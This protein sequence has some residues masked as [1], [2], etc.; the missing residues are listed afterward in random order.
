MIA[1][2]G[3]PCTH[4]DCPIRSRNILVFLVVIG[5]LSVGAY[6]ALRKT[7]GG[8]H[9]SATP[10]RSGVVREQRSVILITV[11]TTRPD[12]LEPYGAEHV[13]TP[14]LSRLASRGIVFE[15]AWAVAPI[16]LVAHTSILSGRY[17]FDHGVRNNGTQYVSPSVTTLA[18]KLQAEGYKTA[19]FVSA[20]VLDKRYGLDQGFDVYDDDLS[21][22][23]NLSPRMVADRPAE[24]TVEATTR[25]L[26]TLGTGEKF[27]TWVHFYD[28]HAGYSPPAPFRDVYRDRLYDGEI[29]YMDEQ[30]G[31]LLAHP[32][33][34]GAEDDEPLVMV[35]G[36][37]GESLGEHGERTHAILAYDSTLH[38][39]WI[40]Y[41]PGGPSG[42]RIGEPVGQVDLMPTVLGMLGME[43][44]KVGSEERSEMAGRD[45]T[46]IIEGRARQTAHPYYSETY[47]PFYT[48][49]WAKL[50]V[51]HRG[52]WK[53]I[54]APTPELYDRIRD[55]RELTDLHGTQ[56][57]V[58]HDLK[59]DLDEW[60]S[61]FDADQEASLSLDSEALAKLRSLG[62]LSVG[63]GRREEGRERPNPMDMIDQHVGLE[64]ARMFLADK[65]YSQAQRQLEGVLRRDPQNLAAL[66]DL[67]RAH[68]GQDQIGEALKLAERALELDPEYTQTYMMLARLEAQR[69]DFNRALELVDLAAERDPGNPDV[70]IQ[71]A[72]FLQRSG[73]LED[74]GEVLAQLLTDHPDHP[75]ANAFYAHFVEARTGQVEEAE[76]RLLQVV[77]WD[78]YLDQAWLFLGRAQERLGR[79][80]AAE[81]SYR[82]G[83]T[84]RP[85]DADLHGALG[86]LLARSGR[87]G[88]AVSQL[89]EAIRLTPRERTELHVSLGSVLAEMGRAEE[90]QRQYDKVLET[91]P[92]H[93]GARNNAAIALYRSGRAEE[94][95]AAL[96]QVVV[97]FPRHADALNNL[98]AIAVDQEEWREAVDYSRKTLDLAPELV[99]AW[100]NLAIGLE[101]IGELVEA[102]SAY[103]KTLA[104]DPEYWPGYFNLGLL[105]KKTEQ[106]AE[107]V[108]AFDQV[109][110]RIP[111]HAETHL[112][113]GELYAD[114]GGEADV[115]KAKAHWN[116]FLRH[117]PAHPRREEILRKLSRL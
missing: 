73:R 25:W 101:G 30:I 29:A 7:S 36:D 64:R 80:D 91:N 2:S 82:K 13:S 97:D 19:A 21:S 40:T 41:L 99:E 9:Q 83:L 8:E 20:A 5:L 59:R 70:R 15:R 12:R 117:A 94:A 10:S 79:T 86:H 39:P 72:G 32:R 6:L 11:D 61:Q 98:A 1:L 89:Q 90:A 78:P 35:I 116:A 26:D 102:R 95:K 54:D 48:Y 68:E 56:T 93:P 113:L 105:F 58:A 52:R 23:R 81:S 104:L 33:L 17:P 50:K 115:A 28:P 67:V 111:N 4:G 75:R 60:L 87:H 103:E 43:Q 71:K 92:R 106:P 69:N 14:T 22:R 77:D 63:S 96:E 44:E 16:T 47:L 18:E 27:F 45:L 57:D 55:P 37:H 109:L 3:N 112:E 114:P 85:D 34:L 38:V 88:E 31:R 24:V 49:G 62:Y 110:T 66:I 100:N 65:L 74:S 51:M 108:A 42:V 107:A 46:P 84:S 76:K 53:L